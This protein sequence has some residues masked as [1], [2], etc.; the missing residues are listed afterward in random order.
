MDLHDQGDQIIVRSV[1]LQGLLLMPLSKIPGKFSVVRNAVSQ[2][3]AA[4]TSCDVSVLDICL[5]YAKAIPWS[6]GIVIGV[7]SVEQLI[8]VAESDFQFPENWDFSIDRL[9]ENILDPRKW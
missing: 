1:F 4:A 6:S 8:Q 9:P 2:L 5:G 3:C 7:A